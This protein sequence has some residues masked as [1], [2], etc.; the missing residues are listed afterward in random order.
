MGLNERAN[1]L[2]MPVDLLTNTISPQLAEDT[3]VA[4]TDKIEDKLGRKGLGKVLY[5]LTIIGLFSA[6]AVY[7]F[8]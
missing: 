8:W 6:I 2:E 5:W 7:Y 1:D 3:Y 4:V